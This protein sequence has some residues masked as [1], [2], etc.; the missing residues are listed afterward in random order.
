MSD[1]MYALTRYGADAAAAE[2]EIARRTE[3]EER[4]APDDGAAERG[5]AV[6]ACGARDTMMA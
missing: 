6:R 4:T 5:P 3:A 1:W 2:R